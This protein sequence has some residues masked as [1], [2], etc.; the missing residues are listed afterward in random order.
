M[1]G[2][3]DVTRLEVTEIEG[4]SR[5]CWIQ[6]RLW[7]CEGNR[8]I[9][10]KEKRDE[11]FGSKPRVVQVWQRNVS[12]LVVFTL[13]CPTRTRLCG[14]AGA[15]VGC[16]QGWLPGMRCHRT[17]AREESIRSIAI[18]SWMEKKRK[19]LCYFPNSMSANPSFH[20]VSPLSR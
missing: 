14:K 5:A 1:F 9:L 12:G 15:I 19:G 10:G 17:G 4:P 6:T 18:Y 3:Y 16:H 13:R 8:T 7:P 2:H 11:K 20:G